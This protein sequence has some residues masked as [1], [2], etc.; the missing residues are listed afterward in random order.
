MR[1]K[2]VWQKEKFLIMSNDVSHCQSTCKSYQFQMHLYVGRVKFRYII[3]IRFISVI[4]N[5]LLVRP[6]NCSNLKTSSLPTI[7]FTA[8]SYFFICLFSLSVL[9]NIPLAGLSESSQNFDLTSSVKNRL[10][11]SN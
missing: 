4:V 7:V 5:L 8:P 9:R 10:T 1:L 2:M 11:F 6:C 3:T